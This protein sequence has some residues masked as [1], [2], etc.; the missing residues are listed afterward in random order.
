M[1]LSLGPDDHPASG[2]TKQSAAPLAT[3]ARRSGWL[4]RRPRWNGPRC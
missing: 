4:A 1:E 2:L 3:S